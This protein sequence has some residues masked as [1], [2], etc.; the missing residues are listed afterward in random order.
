MKKVVSLMV[1]TS[2]SLYGKREKHIC[3]NRNKIRPSLE[4]PMTH[5]PHEKKLPM[6][7]SLLKWV[8]DGS[9]VTTSTNVQK[10]STDKT[11]STYCRKD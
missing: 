5:P 10:P 1:K 2:K 8:N 9:T 4:P 6:I 11:M 3:N 7:P